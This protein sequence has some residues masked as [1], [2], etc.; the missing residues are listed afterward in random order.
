MTI[1]ILNSDFIK[2]PIILYESQA[3]VLLFNEENQ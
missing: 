2:M 3:T 1:A